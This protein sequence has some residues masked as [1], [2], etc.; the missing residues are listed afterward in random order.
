MF[1]RLFFMIFVF[2]QF[3][4]VLAL[5]GVDPCS[6]EVFVRVLEGFVV[7]FCQILFGSHLQRTSGRIFEKVAK[8][9]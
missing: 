6:E 8:N 5:G 3:L 1:D 2:K 7:G 4:I 9:R